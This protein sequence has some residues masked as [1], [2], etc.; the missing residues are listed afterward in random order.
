MKIFAFEKSYL[1]RIEEFSVVLEDQGGASIKE[2]W[3]D[4]LESSM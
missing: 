2:Q 3:I 1:Q 4:F